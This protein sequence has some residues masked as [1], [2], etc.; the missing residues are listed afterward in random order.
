MTRKNETADR[1]AAARAAGR[2]RSGTATSSPAS[3]EGDH[4][5][6]PVIPRTDPVKV[7][8][9]MQPIEHRRLRQF[10]SAV[11]I[12][13]ELTRVAGAEVLRVL[14]ELMQEDADLTTRV[15]RE[16]KRTGGSRRRH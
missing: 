8:V 10:C 1:M 9:E 6:E 4:Q 7:T 14:W 3:A 2:R 16:L 5:D 12:E 13:Y 11:E 15:K